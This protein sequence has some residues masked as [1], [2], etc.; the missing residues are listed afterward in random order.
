MAGTPGRGIEYLR[1]QQ[2]NFGGGGYVS[3]G[4][5][6]FY[7]ISDTQAQFFFLTDGPE[8]HVP[9]IHL[10]EVSR[11]DKSTFTTE[12]I[13]GRDNEGDAVELCPRCVAGADGPF[14]R[15]TAFV[16][17]EA[18]FWPT[19]QDTKGKAHADWEPV[20]S[21]GLTL[22]K[23]TVNEVQLF[24]PRFKLENQVLELFEG[25]PT[26]PDFGTRER[27]LLG[28]RFRLVTTGARQQRQD[29]IH[30]GR[31]VVTIPEAIVAARAGL[32]D[33]AETVNMEWGDK[34]SGK[35]NPMGN[36]ASAK[37]VSGDGRATPAEA[38]TPAATP[39]T[40]DTAA[41][42]ADA[43]VVTLEF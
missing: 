7:G 42:V 37:M 6:K 10:E 33:L 5:N 34:N 15:L 32:K 24:M 9:L 35:N 20:P 26:D 38:A 25:D 23:E 21:S 13:C 14:P 16:Y 30:E 39:D 18:R 27:T 29:I 11:R 40:P 2:E 3:S 4:L 8:L 12:R 28:R 31:Q 41:Q 1:Q 19:Q 36:A 22:Y 17:V 43:T